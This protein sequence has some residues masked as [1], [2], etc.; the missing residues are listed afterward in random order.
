MP[1]NGMVSKIK[2]VL[3]VDEKMQAYS[4]DWS[5]HVISDKETGNLGRLPLI[6]V[7]LDTGTSDNNDMAISLR[8]A[9]LKLLCSFP[10]RFTD[11]EIFLF[12]E[13]AG[14]AIEKAEPSIGDGW[15]NSKMSIGDVKRFTRLSQVAITL[16]V[17]AV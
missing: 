7:S 12:C 3:S 9:T 4:T 14:Q 13:L 5:T 16:N 8:T 2:T 17:N 15:L 11:D 10:R 1:I 6:H